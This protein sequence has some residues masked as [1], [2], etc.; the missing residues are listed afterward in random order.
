M[1]GRISLILY[2]VCLL[3]TC[4]KDFHLS[5][6]IIY[7][8]P[9]VDIFILTFSEVSETFCNLQSIIWYHVQIDMVWLL[10]LFVFFKV[11]FPSLALLLNVWFWAQFWKGVGD[12]TSFSHLWLQQHCLCFYLFWMKLSVGFLYT[13]LLCWHTFPPTLYSLGYFHAC[14]LDFLNDFLYLLNCDTFTLSLFII[15]IIFIDLV[16]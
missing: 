11:K 16:M 6:F 5:K 9:S 3:L 13:V 7:P 12:Q 8:V 14:I 15:A 10:S 1:N 4:R 2:S